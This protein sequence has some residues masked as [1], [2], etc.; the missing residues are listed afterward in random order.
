MKKII[1]LL[2]LI[3]I[4]LFSYLVYSEKDSRPD[5]ELINNFPEESDKQDD[6]PVLEIEEG[7]NIEEVIERRLSFEVTDKEYIDNGDGTVTDPA[8]GLMWTKDFYG[9]STYSN[10]STYIKEYSGYNDW[11][12]PNIKELYSIMDFSGVDPDAN[13]KNTNNLKPFINLNYFNFSYG[14]VSSGDRIIDSQWITTNV[15][16]SKVMRNEECFFGVNFADGRIKCYPTGGRI[17]KGY[18]IRLVRGNQY[19]SND[20]V[21]NNDGTIADNITG[22]IWQ[23]NDSGRGLNWYEAVDYCSNLQVS[24]IR[25]WRLPNIKELQYIV[26]YSRS[27]D[28]TNTA[29]INPIF[30]TSPIK[31]EAGESDYPFFWSST[32]HLNHN[33]SDFAT[34]ISFG[35]AM[36]KMG[37]TWIDVHGAGAQ[38]SDP[39]IGDPNDYPNGFGPQGDARRIYNHARCV[40]G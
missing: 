7:D 5:R 35:R 11:R 31:N 40:S 24:G 14:D 33:G 16:T 2:L 4:V 38:R 30:E 20:F 18:F 34:Y 17:N 15:Y 32:A 6:E 8:T 12:I 23:K 29:A 21:D 22:L 39:K 9:K 1:I 13:S 10:A 19:G 37:G 3:I 27:P 36:G 28:H 25:D 26:D